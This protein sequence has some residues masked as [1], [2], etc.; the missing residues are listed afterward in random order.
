L[1]K[2]LKIHKQSCW[3]ACCCWP[4]TAR[5]CHLNMGNKLWCL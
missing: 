1:H 2:F 4:S 3:N 5:H